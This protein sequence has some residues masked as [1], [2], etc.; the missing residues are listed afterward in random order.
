MIQV[1]LFGTSADPPT[2]GHQAIVEWLATRF[3]WVAVWAADNPFKEQQTLLNHRQTMLAMSIDGIAGCFNNV[4]FCPHLSDVR[5]LNS[6]QKAKLDWPDA[7]FTLVVGAD[8]LD[9]LPHWYRVADLLKAVS[10]LIVPRPSIP[11]T[12]QNLDAL[13]TLGARCQ[14]ATFVGPDVSSTEYRQTRDPQGVMPAIAQYIKDQNLY[15]GLG[16]RQ[17]RPINPRLP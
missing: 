12:P 16:E 4:K 1:A 17:L 15:T 11:I 6:V 5:T 2:V 3:D 10:L 13:R 14:V 8:V 7:Q 9:S